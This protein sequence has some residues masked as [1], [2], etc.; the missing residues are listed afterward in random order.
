VCKD[1]AKF[2]STKF[3]SPFFNVFF[4]FLSLMRSVHILITTLVMALATLPTCAQGPSGLH[5]DVTEHSFGDIAEEGGH[6]SHIFHFTNISSTPIALD[7]VVASCGCTTPE[8][9]R[10]PIAPG[11]K[12]QIRVTFDPRG[13]PGDFS[14][15]ISVVSGGSRFRDFLTITGH[16]IQRPKSIEEEFPFDAGGGVRLSGELLT[17][18]TVA[19]GQVGTMN[20]E[21]VNTGTGPVSLVFEPVEGSGVLGVEAPERL[22]AGC[23]DTISFTYDLSNRTVYGQIYDVV[24]PVVDGVDATGTIYATMTGIDDFSEVDTAIA[25]RFF[26]DDSYRDFG[27]VRRRAMPFIFRTTASNQGAEVLHIRSVVTPEGVVCTLRAGMTI[28]PGAEL[29]FEVILYTNRFSAGEIR[30]SVQLVVDDPMRPTR[31]VWVVALIKN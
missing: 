12:A 5:F 11:A 15:S 16:V 24:R 29:P 30:Q 2:D 1:T 18:R 7:R 9:P 6:V 19:Q 13:L 3:F 21:A 20:I 10:T 27:E 23:R 22:C 8:Y 14:K 28:A 25:P 31:N 4:L 26:L 17:F